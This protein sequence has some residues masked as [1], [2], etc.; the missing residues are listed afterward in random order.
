MSE[1]GP[2]DHLDES[3]AMYLAALRADDP[4]RRAALAHSEQC[5]ACHALWQESLQLLALLDREADALPPASDELLSRV[6]AAV[7]HAP[8]LK[9]WF[10]RLSTWLIPAFALCSLALFWAHLGVTPEPEAV[11]RPH[12]GWGCLRV[13]LGLGVA[14]FALGVFGARAMARQLGTAGSALAAMSGAL[15]GQ[16]LLGSVCRAEQTAVHLLLFH[17]AGVALAALLGGAAGWAGELRSSRSR[18]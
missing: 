14:A 17:V 10:M 16:W 6:Q 4:E 8:E 2:T 9:P 11:P 15:V 3:R 18:A 13:E 5:A 12:H 7:S 1:H